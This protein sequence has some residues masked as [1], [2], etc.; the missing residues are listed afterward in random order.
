MN[1]GRQ[2]EGRP[3]Q[4]NMGGG[5]R[6]MTGAMSNLPRMNSEQGQRPVPKVNNNPQQGRGSLSMEDIQ[7]MV[8]EG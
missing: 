3:H 7:R 8:E 4:E 5:N 2:D 6:P 1:Q